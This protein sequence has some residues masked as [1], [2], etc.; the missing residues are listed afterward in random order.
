MHRERR[1]AEHGEEAPVIQKRGDAHG[2]QAAMAQRTER[3]RQ[4][5]SRGWRWGFLDQHQRGDQRDRHQRRH[6][7]ERA[8]PADAAQHGSDQRTGG[9]ADPECGLVGHDRSRES[10]TRRS[11]DDGQAGGD[12]QGIPQSPA[13]SEAHDLPDAARGAGERA[14]HHDEREPGHESALGADPAADPAS[15]QHCDGRDDQVAGEEQ[16]DL[17]RRGVQLPGERRK[18]RVD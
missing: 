16:F 9:D 5:Q 13:G 1:E 11:D 12:E 15:D 10:A 17:G 18:N 3:R 4:R 2:E 7:E 14:E 8:A 6:A